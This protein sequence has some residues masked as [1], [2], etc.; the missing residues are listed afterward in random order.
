MTTIDDLL[1]VEIF[2]DL[3]PDNLSVLLPLLAELNVP[4]DTTIIYRGD[5]GSSMYMVLNGSVTVTLINDEGVE[6]SLATM[7]AGD[8][9][10][11]MALMT[12]EPRSANV[13]SIT[14]VR[15]L[16]L[17]QNDFFELVASHPA[18]YDRLLKL[19]I[20][21]RSRNAAYQ[22]TLSSRHKGNIASL[23]AESPPNIDQFVGKTNW[24][25]D[26]NADLKRLSVNKNNVLICGE[27]GTGKHLAAQLIHFKHPD[28]SDPLYHLD[29]A[30][31]PPV[32]R[33][34]TTDKE[35][36]N[37]GLLSEV[38]QMSA[39]F[40]HG[41]GAGSFA[42]SLRRG[43]LELADNGTVILENIDALAA[44]V[45]Q[46]LVDF[47][48]HGTFTRSG[49]PE[50]LASRVR[51]LATTT[52]QDVDLVKSGSL[53]PDL[54][55]LVG[56]ERLNLKPLRL[57]KKDIPDIA[58]YCLQEFNRK[59]NKDISGFT[60]DSLNLLVEYLWPFNV[61]GLRQV[62]ERAVVTTSGSVIE[63]GQIFLHTSTF[64]TTGKFN[65]LK[66]PTIRR[67]VNY[68]F[69]PNG[70]RFLTVPFILAL[71]LFTLTGPPEKNPANLVVWAIWWPFLIASIIIS[72]RGWCGYCPLP[73]ISDGI[74]FYR[75]KFFSVPSFLVKNGVWIGIAGFALILLS[76][77]AT[78][79]F[80]GAHATSILLLTILAGAVVTNFF[81]GK[82]VWCK[83]VCPLGK[84]VA[85]S[86]TLSLIGLDS[87]SSVCSSQCLT[88]DCVK[89][90][91]CPMGLHPSAV[92]SSKDCILCLECIKRCKH[93]SVRLNARL[94]WRELL[95]RERW[96]VAGAFFAVSLTALVL[97]VKIPSWKPVSLILPESLAGNALFMDVVV[98]VLIGLIFTAVAFL[99]SGFPRN[100]AWKR[101]FTIAG[102]AYLFLAFAGFFNIYFHEFVY[103]GQNLLPWIVE[104][105]GMSDII[106]A[107]LITPNLGTLKAL[108]PLITL[109]GAASSISILTKLARKHSIS[110]G[111]N[112]THQGIMIA[113][114]LLFLLIL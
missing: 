92:A 56:V 69:F 25:N 108:I 80:T 104:L 11:E 76:E 64:T 1:S 47:I 3:P 111:V 49:D 29:C 110:S 94:P 109:I 16:E 4:A 79:M 90:E 102:Y 84:M 24:T 8:I 107:D 88:H 101:N 48:R 62:V 28:N 99:A 57:R 74:N 87:N 103:Q 40:G 5:P 100:S 23:F 6:Y 43:Y 68:Q 35:K 2:K 65:L 55:T 53:E 41:K 39:L 61:D 96:D 15:L 78:H 82:R 67:L 95:V 113:T 71:I 38:A 83:H 19:L 37:T 33:E 112:K 75:R 27:R 9:F 36:A 44:P 86:T 59:Y 98:A 22:E 30:N 20:Q 13:K 46:R 51:I 85:Q 17:E 50:L 18:I 7:G 72:G 54:L 114:A 105:V 26:V 10:G 66:I 31:P 77:H 45:Q 106:P 97:A 42:Q 32:Q 89:D 52:I 81:F 14:S 70:L 73:T 63:E 12:G 21:R 60:K 58:E 93:Q 34:A 91:S